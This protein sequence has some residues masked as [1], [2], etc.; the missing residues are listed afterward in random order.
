MISCHGGPSAEDIRENIEGLK[1]LTL[2][3]EA[4]SGSIAS[5]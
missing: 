5:Q 2:D 4:S 1:R 3:A